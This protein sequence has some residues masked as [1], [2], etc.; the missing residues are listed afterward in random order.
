MSN[1]SLDKAESLLKKKHPEYKYK[2]IKAIGGEQL[3]VI[4]SYFSA[5]IITLK[6]DQYRFK[7][8]IYN[9]WVYYFLLPLALIIPIIKEKEHKQL[10]DNV[11]SSL[12]TPNDDN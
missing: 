7:K 11:S 5:C 12:N 1:I 10:L 2:R 9:T 6:K 8:T 3:I 4:S